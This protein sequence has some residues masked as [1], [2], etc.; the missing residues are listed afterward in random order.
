MD[1]RISTF[2][3]MLLT[4]PGR[5]MIKKILSASEENLIPGKDALSSKIFQDRKADNQCV[6]LLIILSR[7]DSGCDILSTIL[8]RQCGWK[9]II[10]DT[11]ALLDVLTLQDG[12]YK[13]ECALLNIMKYNS[14]ILN[15][16]RNCCESIFDIDHITKI[17]SQPKSQ[18]SPRLFESNPSVNASSALTKNLSV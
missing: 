1:S 4:D 14:N 11:D 6:N 15:T 9:N 10:I 12:I 18:Y 13:G 8:Q 7:T 16:I 2:D 5:W 17:I 3:C